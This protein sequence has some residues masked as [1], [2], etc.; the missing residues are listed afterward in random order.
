MPKKINQSEQL[1]KQVRDDLVY[2]I[3]EA[4]QAKEMR[5]QEMSDYLGLNRGLGQILAGRFDGRLSEAIEI[6]NTLGYKMT[7]GVAKY[8]PSEKTKLDNL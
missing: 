2:V 6:F 7:I 5:M 3:R 1:M 8:R 4:M